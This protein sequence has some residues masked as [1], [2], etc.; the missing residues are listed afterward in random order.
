[1]IEE[2]DIAEE[3]EEMLLDDVLLGVTEG[4]RDGVVLVITE[5]LAVEEELG[6][7]VFVAIVEGLGVLL[8]VREELDVGVCEAFIVSE[9]HG[10]ARHLSRA[11]RGSFR[12]T[13]CLR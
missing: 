11:C 9:G 10:R 12:H 5:E 13:C 7:V 3:I 4:L 8:E 6:A 1:M 2:L